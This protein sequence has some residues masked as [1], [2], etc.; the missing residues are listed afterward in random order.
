MNTRRI[1]TRD[2]K[3]IGG[4]LHLAASPTFVAMALITGIMDAGPARIL[5]QAMGHG[6]VSLDSM[7]FMYL[8]MAAFHA[9][10][11]WKL[12]AVRAGH[13]ATRGQ[14]RFARPT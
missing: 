2:G 12:I 3:E 1:K 14:K 5:C 13:A 4:W 9:S 7:S 6:W 11:W 8:L 10:P